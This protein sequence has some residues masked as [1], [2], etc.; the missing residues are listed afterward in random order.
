M[1][2]L[3]RSAVL[4]DAAQALDV[5][6]LSITE[7]CLVHH[8]NDLATL[9]QWLANTQVN[10]FER[11]LADPG[12][13]VAVALTDGMLTGVLGASCERERAPTVEHRKRSPV[14]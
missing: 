8:Q 4:E 5:L 6:R 14:L 7:L 13:E 2:S 9:E 11:W 1:T 12:N 3:V 10:L